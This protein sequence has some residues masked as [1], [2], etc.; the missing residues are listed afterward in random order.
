MIDLTIPASAAVT[1]NGV[2]VDHTQ[3]RLTLT[4]GAIVVVWERGGITATLDGQPVPVPAGV[5]WYTIPA[6]E[7]L[8]EWL[9]DMRDL[10]AEAADRGRA[11][12]RLV[13]GPDARRDLK[14]A[15]VLLGR[16]VAARAP[17]RRTGGRSRRGRVGRVFRRRQGRR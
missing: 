2:V 10:V 17:L 15:N 9:E 4:Q 13:V 5:D 14:P 8:P 1:I 11:R 12:L 3:L 16:H 6:A 7:P